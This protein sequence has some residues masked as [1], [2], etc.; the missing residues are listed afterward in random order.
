MNSLAEG[1]LDAR[2]YQF[3][4]EKEK[5]CIKHTWPLAGSQLVLTLRVYVL[6]LGFL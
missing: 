5:V 1:V 2:R 4:E 3:Q 6:S